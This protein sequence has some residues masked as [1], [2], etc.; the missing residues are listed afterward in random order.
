RGMVEPSE[1]SAVLG[2]E[3]EQCGTAFV[4]SSDPPPLID[5]LKP[6]DAAARFVQSGHESPGRDVPQLDRTLPAFPM[7]V[8]GHRM[9]AL[10][11]AESLDHVLFGNSPPG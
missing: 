3:H 9:R 4:E 5:E 2:R 8:G 6:F 7:Q 11:A 10:V 1:H